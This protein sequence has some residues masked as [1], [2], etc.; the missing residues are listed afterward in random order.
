M[1]KETKTTT[2][3]AAVLPSGLASLRTLVQ[4][5]LDGV[6]AGDPAFAEKYA[7]PKKSLDECCMFLA[8]EAWGRAKGS[9][10]VYIQPEELMGLAVHYYD[11]DEIKI[12]RLPS[13]V[14]ARAD[15]L[16]PEAMKNLTPEQKAKAEKDALERYTQMQVRKQEEK[17]KE[18]REAE[19]KRR[20]EGRKEAQEINDAWEGASL[21]D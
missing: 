19:A 8:G 5:H 10:C 21:F 4:A 1:A 15:T 7:N 6:A 14:G 11:E 9:T 12:N 18:R 17:D 3:P 20:K 13:G 2:K 16:I